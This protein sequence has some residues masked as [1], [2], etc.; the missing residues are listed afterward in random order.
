MGESVCFRLLWGLLN[1]LCKE[2]EDAYETEPTLGLNCG[3]CVSWLCL[4]SIVSSKSQSS[5]S[6]DRSL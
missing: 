4:Y 3:K 1:N 5:K 2:K 6:F